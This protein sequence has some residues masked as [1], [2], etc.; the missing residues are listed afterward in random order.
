MTSLPEESWSHGHVASVEGETGAF[1]LS[2]LHISVR[3]T[4][5]TI[6]ELT[7]QTVSELAFSETARNRFAGDSRQK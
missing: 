4:A 7:F 1:R 6:R 3:F 2:G 5:E